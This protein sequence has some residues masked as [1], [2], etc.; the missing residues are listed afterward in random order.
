MLPTKPV[1]G[2]PHC[3][4]QSGFTTNITFKATRSSS[5]DGRSVDTDAYEVMSETN[6][7]CAD[8]GRP[9][10]ALFRTAAT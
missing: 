10:R 6:P 3:G 7:K 5:W 8:C 1:T 4:G 9:V 2:C